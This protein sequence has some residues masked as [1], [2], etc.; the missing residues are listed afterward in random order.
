VL[1]DGELKPETNHKTFTKLKY[2]ARFK[3]LSIQ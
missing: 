2:S 3:S 1:E